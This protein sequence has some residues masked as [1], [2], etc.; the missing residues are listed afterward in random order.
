MTIEF[1]KKLREMRKRAGLSQE[2]IALELH[3]SISN[4]SRIETGKYHVKAS[5]AWKWMNI[6]G[7]QEIVAAMALGIDITVLQQ[8]LE[9][10]T[11]LVATIFVGGIL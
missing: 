2:D 6:T 8:A 5:D 4:I 1:G 10:A 11:K 9:L 3:M 7:S